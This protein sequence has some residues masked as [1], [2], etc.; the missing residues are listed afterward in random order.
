MCANL[1]IDVP[2][3]VGAP[4]LTHNIQFLWTICNMVL[5]LIPQMQQDDGNGYGYGISH[6]EL[7][8]SYTCSPHWIAMSIAIVAVLT[9]IYWITVSVGIRNKKWYKVHNFKLIEVHG[10]CR[11]SV[12]FILLGFCILSL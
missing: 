6:L 9:H 8:L 1:N 12:L 10:Y 7:Q 4:H 5:Y 3:G 2:A 11:L